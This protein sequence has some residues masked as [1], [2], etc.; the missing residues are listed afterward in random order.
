VKLIEVSEEATL[1]TVEDN[2]DDVLPEDSIHIVV[3][4]DADDNF[5]SMMITGIIKIG[6]WL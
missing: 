4:V 1:I 5:T 2:S 6:P 3:A